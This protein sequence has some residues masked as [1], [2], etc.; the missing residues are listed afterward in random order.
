MSNF[1]GIKSQELFLAKRNSLS[2]RIENATVSLRRQEN[3]VV[4]YV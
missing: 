2:M 4:F 3:A 1:L